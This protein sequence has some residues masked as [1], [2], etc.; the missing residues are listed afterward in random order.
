MTGQV[1]A[2]LWVASD[3]P[4][5]DFVVK[6]CDVY[7]DGRSL[8]VCE[9]ILRARFREGFDRERFLKPGQ[10]VR[11]NIDLWATSIIF[12]KGHRL[13]VLVTSSSA[14]ANDPNP[15][16]GAGFRADSKTQIAHNTLYL[17]AK[18]PSHIL[19]PVAKN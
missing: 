9:G 18:R 2:A 1:R 16:T 3:A 14:P 13:R 8:N 15:N 17:D 4:D 10:P 12:N 6:L 7:P 5:T 19:L 11:L